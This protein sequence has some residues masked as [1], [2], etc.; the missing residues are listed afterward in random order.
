MSLPL[1]V[2]VSLHAY[3]YKAEVWGARVGHETT[4]INWKST[5]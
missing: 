1:P 2:F 3:L 4:S 5:L